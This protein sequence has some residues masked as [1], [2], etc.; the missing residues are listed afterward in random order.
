MKKFAL[1]VALLVGMAAA[2]D[3]QPSFRVGGGLIFDGTVFGG[4]A[5][6]DIPMSDK[7]YGITI[8]GEYY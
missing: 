1:L 3:A 8:Q 5:A 6:V 2:A 7:P 4:G